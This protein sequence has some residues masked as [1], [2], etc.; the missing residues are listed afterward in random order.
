MLK[1][2]THRPRDD[3][4][5]RSSGDHLCVFYF[6][7]KPTTVWIRYDCCLTTVWLQSYRQKKIP[8]LISGSWKNLN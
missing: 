6:F 7:C 2:I 3:W 8:K 5:N 1:G 4:A